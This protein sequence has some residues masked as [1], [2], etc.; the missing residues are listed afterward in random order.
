MGRCG[1]PQCQY[2]GGITR[3]LGGG[4]EWYAL[5]TADEAAQKGSR[6]AVVTSIRLPAV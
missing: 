2:R 6:I 5:G 3:T 1:M 4:V